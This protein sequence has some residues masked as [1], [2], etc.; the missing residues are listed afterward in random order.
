MD[1][2]DT[3]KEQ[4]ANNPVL[5][6]MKGAPNAPQCG[7]SA[8]AVQAL[9]ACG[10]KFA[11]VDILQ[12]PEIRAN[13]PAYANWPTFPQLWINGEL[14]GGSDIILELHESGELQEMIKA[15]QPAA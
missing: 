7:F 3:I 1:I 4:I 2:I 11:Y 6:Y 8:R 14:V 10:E 5:I 13:L 15:A 12:N 9:M